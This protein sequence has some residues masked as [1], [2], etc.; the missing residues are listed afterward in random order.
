MI[1]QPPALIALSDEIKFDEEV[2]YGM[3]LLKEDIC[4][5]GRDDSCNI[6]VRDKIISRH[7][8]LI[9]RRGPHFYIQ[10]LS[11]TNKTFVNQRKIDKEQLLKDRDE[12]GLSQAKAL[13]RFEDPESTEPISPPLYYDDKLMKFFFHKQPVE[14]RRKELYLLHHLYRNAGVVCLREKCAEVVWEREYDPVTD[15]DGQIGRAHV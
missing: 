15:D 14:L 10:N 3:F 5:I 1:V 9:E 4:L 11:N 12:I 8:A 2:E 7:H 6:I 13:F